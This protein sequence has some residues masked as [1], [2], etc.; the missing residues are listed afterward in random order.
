MNRSFK[1]I[2]KLLTFFIGAAVILLVNGH[3]LAQR[4]LLSINSNWLYAQDNSKTISDVKTKW[5]NISLPHTWNQ[6]DVVDATPGYRRDASWYKKSIDVPK[7]KDAKYF[8]YFEG[9]NITSTLYVNGKLVGEH[10]GGYV[11]FEYDITPYVK[12]GKRNNIAVRVDNSYNIHVIPSQKADFYIMGGITRDVWLKIVSSSHIQ[13]LQISTP[14]VS[15]T[16]A[17]TVAKVNIN[18]DKSLK[19]DEIS[20]DIIDPVTKQSVTSNKTKVTEGGELNIE[21]PKIA[22]PRLWSPSLPQRYEAVVKLYSKGKI[23]DHVSDKIGYRW[24][25]F[26]PYGAFFLNGERLLIRGTHRHEDHAGT[27]PAMSNAQHVSDMVLIK[28]MGANFVRLAHYPQDPSVYNA[29]DSLGLIV[30]DELPWCRGGLGDKEW[31]DNTKRLLREQIAMNYNHPSICFWSVGNEVY[32][33]PD[34][35]NGDELKP[36]NV[37]LT[38]LNNICHELDPNRLTAIRKYYEGADLID[39]FS[40]S[41]WSGWYAGLYTNYKETLTANQKKYN[42]FLHMEYGGTSHVGRHTASP[43][44]GEGKVLSDKEWAEVSNQVGVANVAQNGDNSE[45]Y[46][47]DLFDWYLHVSETQPGFGGNAQ[48]AFKDF[49]T[50]L[51]PEDPIPYVNQKGLTDRAGIPKDAYYVFKSYWATKPF[52]YIESHTWTERSGKTGEAQQTR[53]YSN[54][55]EVELF[56]NGKSLGRKK[57]IANTLPA[58]GLHWSVMYSEGKNSLKAI[59]YSNGKEVATDLIDVNF[60][61]KPYDKA[62]QITLDKSTLPNGNILIEAIAR[63]KNGKRV[64]DYEK[65]IYFDHNGSGRLLIDLGTPYGSQVLEMSNGRATVILQPDTSGQCVIEA[66]NQDF[67]GSYIT[68]NF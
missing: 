68:V 64:L 22:N 43:V 18:Q 6:Y 57:K 10:I 7:V 26:E 36:M 16:S 25:N 62:D 9:A 56:Q 32:W 55:Q 39:V 47:V 20:I 41:I 5:N 24:F 40:P 28:E 13:S 23:I 66:R 2:T 65:R 15:K 51:R 35:P 31:Q 50:P 12:A 44:T 61:Y 37:F 34:F 33:L 60:T 11:A 38:E 42:R 59:A 14:A 21:L 29:C 46:I 48:W 52:A 4:Q 19:A 58:G 63:D 8:L 3:A 27:G 1:N 30:W 45:N 49:A 17:S 53:V 67:K 54:A